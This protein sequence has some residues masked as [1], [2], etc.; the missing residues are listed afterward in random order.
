MTLLTSR[1]RESRRWG[2]DKKRKPRIVSIKKV[3]VAPRGS[4]PG[5]KSFKK[6]TKDWNRR[7]LDQV[8]LTGTKGEES[9]GMEDEGGQLTRSSSK[10]SVQTCSSD[11]PEAPSISSKGRGRPETTGA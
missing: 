7:G 4:K 10:V 1:R 11:V 6:K 9:D 2:N 3:E 5:L 8:D